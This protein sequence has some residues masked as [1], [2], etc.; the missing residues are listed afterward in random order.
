MVQSGCGAVPCFTLYTVKLRS[1][2]VFFLCVFSSC[3]SCLVPSGRCLAVMAGHS[4]AVTCGG[5]FGAGG[6]RCMSGSEDGTVR[7]WDP[8]S[9]AVA[10]VFQ[11]PSFHDGPVFALR[12]SNDT[13]LLLSG[14]ADGTARLLH[15][16]TMKQLH[17]L[18]G[19]EES[20]EDVAFC[21]SY[22]SFR[23][24]SHRVI[25][26]IAHNAGTRTWQPHRWMASCA[27]LTS[28]RPP[29]GTPAHTM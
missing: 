21:E 12:A 27:C 19:H 29:C 14:G 22:V 15:S 3:L 9:G 28:T 20:V 24:R 2:P 17:V 7:L 10:G 6:K 11:G 13:P 5:F 8:R 16:D 26:L 18:K 23:Y 1:D 25:V 4:G